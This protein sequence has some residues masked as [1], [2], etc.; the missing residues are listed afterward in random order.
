MNHEIIAEIR[1]LSVV[2][3]TEED[4]VHALNGVS[5]KLYKGETTTAL[6][7]MRLLPKRVGEI[8]SG[9]IYFEGRDLLKCTEADMRAIRGAEISMIF[10]DPMTSLNPV[11]KVGEQIAESI[12]QH[13]P[14]MKKPQV[15]KRVEEILEMVG[16]PASRKNEYPHQF[17]GGMKQRVVIAIALALE[18]RLL[19]ADEPTTA[20]DVTIQAQ[21]LQMMGDLQQ[22]LGTSTI[23]ITHDLGVVSQNCDRVAVM[24]AGEVVESGTAK[25]IF[26]GEKHHPYTQGLFGSLPD[27][28]HETRRL[29][30]ID[31]LMP[32]MTQVPEGCKF[33]PR[34]PHCTE[35]CRTCQP[36]LKGTEDHSIRC[37]L[38]SLE[39]EA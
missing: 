38:V 13:E 1:D 30:P 24:Y 31:G 33:A 23:L 20:L 39:G 21:V 4:D 11:L 34:C 28:N 18:P 17:S 36:Q 27:L 14:D 6:S 32:D 25:E 7:I 37:H 12:R 15:E 8:T 35:Q 26:L 10:Q 9:E 2:Y 19:L 3:H 29:S 16:I 5:L 22:K